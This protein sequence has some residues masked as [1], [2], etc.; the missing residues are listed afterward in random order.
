MPWRAFQA[1]GLDNSGGHEVWGQP[2]ESQ[3]IG[4]VFIKLLYLFPVATMQQS[5]PRH[6]R[7]IGRRSLPSDLRDYACPLPREPKS[8][9][10]STALRHFFDR[11][12]TPTHPA[13]APTRARISYGKLGPSHGKPQTAR[14]STGPAPLPTGNSASLGLRLENRK[15]RGFPQGLEPSWIS[16]MQLIPFLFLPQAC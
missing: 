8:R 12:I 5:L 2:G 11:F 16:I 15:E 1:G 13:P 14:L 6:N 3:G 7:A 9:N 4:F 10:V